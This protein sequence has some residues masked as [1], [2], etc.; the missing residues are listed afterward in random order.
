MNFDSQP[1]PETMSDTKLFSI[2]IVVKQIEFE[3]KISIKGN[4]TSCIEFLRYR[5]QM[6]FDPVKPTPSEILQLNSGK[7][8]M[9]GLSHEVMLDLC[10]KFIVNLSLQQV[11][12]GKRLSD[13]KLDITKI[14]RELFDDTCQHV[15]KSEVSQ[16]I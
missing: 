16:F 7:T 11:N 10:K 5:E 12:P 3:P 1:P 15:L 14:Y 8:F 6:I 13:A 9:F 2:S 4:V